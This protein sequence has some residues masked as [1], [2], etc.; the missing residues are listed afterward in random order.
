MF[1]EAIGDLDADVARLIRDFPHFD[2]VQQDVH[3]A[4]WERVVPVEL[5]VKVPEAIA[6]GIDR[7]LSGGSEIR[8][9][10][11]SLSRSGVQRV[12]GTAF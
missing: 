12:S 6:L 7:A 11:S 2:A 4:C 10:V 3:V 1:G 5:G 8:Y 9:E